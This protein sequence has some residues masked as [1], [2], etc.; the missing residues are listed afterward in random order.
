VTSKA[1]AIRYA[2]A[3]FDVALK[4]QDDLARVEEQLA[5][6]VDLFSQHP[7]LAKVLLNPAVPVPRKRA[8]V[9]DLTAR[10]QTMPILSKLLTLLAERDRLGVLP[11]LL[12]S[13]RDRLLDHRQVV[14]AE[15]T[16]A[17]PL[18]AGR[19]RE[20]EARLAQVT[21]KTVTVSSRVEPGI[22]GGLIARIGSIVYD[23]SVT[24]QLEKIRSRL[25]EGT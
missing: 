8:A 14:R 23:A 1:A 10:L 4:E 17:V 12:A 25:I 15:I 24:R 3:L 6:F 18:S 13:Y 2:R 16:T 22:I 20:I 21:G 11:D 5:A 7:T 9:G 19:A